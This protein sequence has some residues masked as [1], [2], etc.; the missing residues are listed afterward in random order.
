[1]SAA[2]RWALTA[3]LAFLAGA[4]PSA[5]SAGD[6]GCRHRCDCCCNGSS[7]SGPRDNRESRAA[8]SV[9]AIPVVEVMPV[10]F[11]AGRFVSEGTRDSGSSRLDKLENQ[12]LDLTKAIEELRQTAEA[13]NKSLEL[14]Y[15][16]MR[17]IPGYPTEPN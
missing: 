12:V 9:A 11:M 8:R 17:K 10:A 3:A 13:Q 5:A 2:V 14:M 1:M 15:S 7:K 16:R 4:M 6:C